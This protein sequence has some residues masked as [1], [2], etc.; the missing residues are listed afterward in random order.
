MKGVSRRYLLMRTSS[1]WG[2]VGPFGGSVKVEVLLSPPGS[3]DLRDF[4]RLTTVFDRGFER[5]SSN[6]YYLFYKSTLL[7]KY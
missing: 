3:K 5:R 7:Q 2:W 1:E 4:A 6:L